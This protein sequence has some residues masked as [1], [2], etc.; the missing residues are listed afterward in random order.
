VRKKPTA[1]LDLEFKV[2]NET[3]LPQYSHPNLVFAHTHLGK[4]HAPLPLKS[5]QIRLNYRKAS[6]SYKRLRSED[7]PENPNTEH[8]ADKP[9]TYI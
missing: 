1:I 5:M 8:A 6:G 2:A 7:E 9:I 4:R 3:A